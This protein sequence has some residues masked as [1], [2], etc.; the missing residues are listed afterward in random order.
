MDILKY[1][2]RISIILFFTLTISQSNDIV[3]AKEIYLSYESYPKRVF[4]N[5]R[6]IIKLKAYILKEDESFDSIV[7]T[8]VDQENIDITT[9]K[10]IWEKSK[11]SLYF[12]NISFKVSKQKFKMPLITVALIKDNEIIDYKSIDPLDIEYENIAIDQQLFC[13]VIAN[14]LQINSIK[15]K[16]YSNNMLL[17]TINI[18]SKYSN[19]EDFEIQ[20]YKEQGIKHF[21]NKDGTQ[22]IYYYLLVPSHT[23]QIDFS[24]YN[25]LLKEF[26]KISLPV[27]LSQELVSTQTDLNPYNSN[28][29]I[30]KQIS[31]IFLLLL[32]I[33]GYFIQKKNIYILAITIVLIFL[34]YLFIPNKK[35]IIDKDTKVYILPSTKSTIFQTT[36]EKKL[37]EIINQKDNFTKVLFQN[38]IIGWIKQNDK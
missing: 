5:Q 1:L 32:F 14:D 16:Q 18:D 31:V 19:I 21:E 23:K 36:N 3:K 33:I 17:S 34:T 38:Q 37:V 11:D 10:P 15:T 22:N 27:E 28:I 2:L 29:L 6:F 30:Y 35:I 4:S 9:T 7:T 12:T 24:Y 13:N 20:G 8:F 25:I 26:I